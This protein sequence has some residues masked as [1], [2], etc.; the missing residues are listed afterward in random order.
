MLRVANKL[1]EITTPQRLCQRARPVGRVVQD[2]LGR[3]ALA[4]FVQFVRF[5]VK[6]RCPS[7]LSVGELEQYPEY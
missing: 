4:L 2:I 3:Q 5:V 6:N 1:R 7:V